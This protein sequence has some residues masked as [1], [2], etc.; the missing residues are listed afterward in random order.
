MH[1]VRGRETGPS[2]LLIATQSP[3]GK[4]CANFLVSL[5][6]SLPFVSAAGWRADFVF[7]TGN[8]HVDDA[9]NA[10]V[11]Q[12]MKTD[13]TD[14]LFIDSDVGFTVEGLLQL[15]RHDVDLVAGVYP[16]K[17]EETDFP[18]RPLP[19][20]MRAVKGLVEVEGAP[21]GFMRL[22]RS[23]F[24]RLIE[25]H[26]DRQFIG[27]DGGDPYTILFERTFEGGHRWSGDYAFCRKWRAIGG[28]VWVDPEIDF[29]HEGNF[30]WRGRLGDF[31]KRRAGL[32][33]DRLV[34]AAKRLP[35]S[36]AFRDLYNA[37]GSTWAA[38]PTLLHAA[39]SVSNG[40]RVLETGSGLTTLVMALAGADV[41]ALEHDLAHYRA[42]KA[43]LDQFGVTANV[44]YAPLDPETGWYRLPELPDSFDVLVCDGPPR[45]ISDRNVLWSALADK[46]ANAVWLIDDVRGEWV[47]GRNVHVTEDVHPW[48]LAAPE[49][50][51]EA[52]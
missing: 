25:A 29:T 2:R 21:T 6:E 30:N 23:V 31:W 44:H 49:R 34:E 7:E 13:C 4:V 45:N 38:P 8:C 41:H 22:R 50:K 17:Q 24:E 15:L 9:R 1:Y 12:F 26:K 42:T 33:S 52:A 28:N 43:M 3:D 32:V 40:K 11:R 46:I 18:V 19:G 48:G 37:Y 27:S 5:V 51:S 47:S 35:D 10:V 36:K 39:W 20:E 16:K 14:L